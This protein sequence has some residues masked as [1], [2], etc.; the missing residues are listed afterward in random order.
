MEMTTE[1][2]N[3][4][5]RRLDEITADKIKAKATELYGPAGRP[6]SPTWG[7]VFAA[8]KAGEITLKE[9]TEDNTNAYLTPNDVVWPAM[10]AKKAELDAYKATLKAE[11]QKALDAVM[12]D[13]TASEAL[14]NYEAL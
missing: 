9:G 14:A 4:F 5:I 11:R 7:T 2:R 1:Q 10:E 13:A 3:Y 8:I 12:L 6:E